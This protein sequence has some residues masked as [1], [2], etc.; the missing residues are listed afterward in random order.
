M[1]SS[2]V[3]ASCAVR[4]SGCVVLFRIAAAR[5]GFNVGDAISLYD[6]DFRG[7][8]NGPGAGILAS[9]NDCLIVGLETY[10]CP[11]DECL[12]ALW[13]PGEVED[14]GLLLLW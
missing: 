1:H 9:E 8:F 10:G 12:D 3:F 6:C 7:F 5:L 2:R 11:P 14:D 13:C 4:A